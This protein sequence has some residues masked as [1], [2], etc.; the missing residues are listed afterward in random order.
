MNVDNISQGQ[1]SL[2]FSTAQPIQST[3]QLKQTMIQEWELNI[4][5][6]K[7]VSTEQGV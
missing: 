2:I 3:T 1:W 6:Y 5:K 7:L 4:Q